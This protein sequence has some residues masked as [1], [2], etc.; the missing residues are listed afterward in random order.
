MPLPSLLCVAFAA[1][2]AAALAGKVELRVSPRPALLTRSFA[3][4]LLF[5]IFVLIPVSVY[6]YIFH[7]DWFLL[8][9]VDV[10]SIPS[11]LALLGF[12]VQ[13]G[14][15][16]LGF[17]IGASMARHQR[18][19]IGAV[20]SLLALGGAGA[21]ALVAK[22]RLAMVGS[23]AQFRGG[24]GLEPFGGGALVQ[25]TI[26]MGAIMLVGMAALL[27]RLRSSGRRGD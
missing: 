9:T 21:V 16:A 10:R 5:A 22:E 6:F 4:F 11:A 3:A 15:G 1:G 26:V 13:A 8:Y 12:I 7:G 17:L 27:L 25:G 19:G 24:F 23:F 20:L 14:L 18:E 2:I